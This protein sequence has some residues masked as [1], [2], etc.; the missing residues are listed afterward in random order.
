MH[1]FVLVSAT[2]ALLSLSHTDAHGILTTPKAEF[3]PNVMRTKY[4]ETVAGTSIFPGKKFDDSPQANVATFTQS[5]KESQYKTLRDLVKDK[6]AECGFTISD[7]APQPVPQDGVVVWQN[8]D[9]NEG[10]VPSHTGPCEIWLDDKRVFSDENCA[11]RFPTHPQAKIPVDFSS[12]QGKC[13]LRFYWLALHEPMWQVYKNCVPLAGQ[14]GGNNNN[15]NNNNNGG[16]Y[17]PSTTKSP[18]PTQAPSGPGRI[19]VDEYSKP[20]PTPSP[21]SLPSSA[22][23]PQPSPD[24][25]KPKKK[26]TRRRYLRD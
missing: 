19:P 18:E 13:M 9:T 4:V 11:A 26:C 2:L 24:Q 17:S 15:N 23:A 12:C 14:G 25:K 10:F 22:P 6:G 21:A 20:T 8:P 3:Q 1:S 7:G 5:F 16:E